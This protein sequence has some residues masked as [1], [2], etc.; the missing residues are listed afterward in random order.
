MFDVAL[1]FVFGLLGYVMLKFG[2]PVIP[3]VLG[4]ILGPLGERYLMR[5]LELGR[6]EVSYF[7]GSP[8]AIGLWVLLLVVVVATVVKTVRGAKKETPPEDDETALARQAEQ[9][10]AD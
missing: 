7:F 6:Y 4:L 5:A 2:F 1:A 9:S 3:M 8:L 10:L